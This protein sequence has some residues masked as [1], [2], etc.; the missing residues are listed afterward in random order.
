MAYKLQITG[1]DGVNFNVKYEKLDKASK[2]EVE[3]R[4]PDGSVVKE[5]TV[6]NGQV[7]G[8]GATQR[9]YCDDKGNQFQ[10]Q[11]LKFFF[12]GEFYSIR[13]GLEKSPRTCPVWPDTHLESSQ[14]SS[15][16]ERQVS[17]STNDDHEDHD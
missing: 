4:A 11:E 15:L 2:P 14:R 17:K 8:P 16:N 13:N 6:Y 7:L 5:R 9:K 10:K 1:P 3:A 12:E